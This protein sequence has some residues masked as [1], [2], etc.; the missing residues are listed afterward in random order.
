MF[1]TVSLGIMV[2]SAILPFVSYD[3]ATV[4]PEQPLVAIGAT[5][6]GLS[7]LAFS[8]RYLR[9]SAANRAQVCLSLR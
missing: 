3:F 4:Q 1:T 5:F 9:T 6:L 2:A 7:N 8:R